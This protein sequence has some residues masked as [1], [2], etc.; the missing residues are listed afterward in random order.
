[1]PRRQPVSFR[2]PLALLALANP[3]RGIPGLAFDGLHGL[4]VRR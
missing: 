4:A 3:P 2:S 1:M